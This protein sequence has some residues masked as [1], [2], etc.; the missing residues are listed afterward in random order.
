[1]V[2]LGSVLVPVGG[3]FLSHFA[4]MRKGVDVAAVYRRETMPSFNVA[5]IGAWLLG[6]I[7]YRLATPI[8]ATLPA[9]ATSIVVYLLLHRFHIDVTRVKP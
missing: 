4:M 7:V 3:V 1:M 9:L 8:G 6:V 2:L 5:G